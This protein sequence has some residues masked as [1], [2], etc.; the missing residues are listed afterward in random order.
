MIAG[1]VT[2]VADFTSTG[3][4]FEAAQ[5]VGLR[6]K[7]YRSVGA[8]SKSQVDTAIEEA[9]AD[10]ERWRS[11]ADSDRMQIGIAPKALHACH[12]TIF[13][14][15]NE[16]A[17]KLDLPV[18]MHVA[19]SYEEYSYIMRGSTPLSVRGIETGGDALT[20]RPM[21]LPTALRLST[22]RS[23]GTLS[24]ATM[25]LLHIVCTLTTMT[26]RSSKSMTW[27]FR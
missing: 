22:M 18:A 16:V 15:V 12:P 7:F 8:T 1:G 24:I 19:G 27:P 17:E 14:K 26:L 4:S 3:A 23:T 9:V 13:S 6:G 10:I 25:C 20:D 5:D 2:T 21:W 11:E